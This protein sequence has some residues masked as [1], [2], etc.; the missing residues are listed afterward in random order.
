LI[1][2]PNFL[3]LVKEVLH[4]ESA[5]LVIKHLVKLYHP[6]LTLVSEQVKHSNPFFSTRLTIVLLMMMNTKINFGLNPHAIGFVHNYP[7]MCT[8]TPTITPTLITRT[9]ERVCVWSNVECENRKAKKDLERESER[10]GDQSKLSS[11]V[12]ELKM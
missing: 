12:F 2:K 1:L 10:G 3:K 5:G 9:S 7:A 11:K 6:G 4:R 8:R